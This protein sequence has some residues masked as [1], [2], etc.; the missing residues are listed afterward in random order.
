MIGTTLGHYRLAAKI[1]EGGTGVVHLP[2]GKRL[3]ADTVPCRVLSIRY[4]R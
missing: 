4:Y 3:H 2:R 1:D